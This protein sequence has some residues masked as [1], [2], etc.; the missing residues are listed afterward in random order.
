MM[1]T[2]HFLSRGRLPLIAAITVLLSSCAVQEQPLPGLSG[3]SELGLGMSIAAAPEFLPRDGSSIS[4]ITVKTFDS[5]GVPKPNQPLRITASAG[6][7][8]ASQV[9]TGPDGSVQ[10]SYIAPGLNENV[11]VV[12]IAATPIQNTHYENANPRLVEI[13]VSGPAIPVASFN[14]TP[15]AP[16]QFELVTLDASTSALSGRQCG[17]VCT[18]LWTFPDGSTD[19]RRIAQ[20]RFQTVG[21]QTVSLLVTAPSGTFSSTSRNITVGNPVAPTVTL[22]FSPTNPRNGNVVNFTATAQAANGATITE[23]RWNFGGGTGAAPTTTTGANTA[24]FVAVQSTT[25]LVTV[26]AVDSNNSMTT[27]TATVSVQP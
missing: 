26:T 22:T 7:L 11:S 2:N 24:T 23:Y 25:Y 9:V 1:S 16:A 3:P 10:F 12:T 6:T 19:D 4:T 14:F 20:K 27:A 13:L 5:N 8:A 18:Y 17:D 21:L 15:P